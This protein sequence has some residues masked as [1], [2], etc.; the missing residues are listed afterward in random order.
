MIAIFETL[1]TLI[2]ALFMSLVSIPSLKESNK[3]EYYTCYNQYIEENPNYTKDFDD[4][5]DD[6][7]NGKLGLFI[8]QLSSY[9]TKPSQSMIYVNKYTP[10]NFPAL[11]DGNGHY[12]KGWVYDGS[13]WDFNNIVSQNMRLEAAWEK[14]SEHGILFKNEDASQINVLVEEGTSNFDLRIATNNYNDF[15]YEKQTYKNNSGIKISNPVVSIDKEINEYTF[16][17]SIGASKFSKKIVITKPDS[18]TVSFDTKGLIDIS[19][20]EVDCGT[21]LES[22][23]D[24]NVEGY[25]FMGWEY[26]NTPIYTNTILKAKLYSNEEFLDMINKSFNINFK[27]VSNDF[28][29]PIDSDLCGDETIEWK[30]ENLETDG[31]GI[32]IVSGY[33]CRVKTRITSIDASGTE[34]VS[35]PSKC[36][37]ILTITVKNTSKTYEY[38]VTVQSEEKVIKAQSILDLK[39][40]YILYEGVNHYL[41]P[42]EAFKCQVSGEILA[43]GPNGF[44]IFD[45]TSVIYVFTTGRTT[46]DENRKTIEI[47][48]YVSIEGRRTSY[49]N[50]PQIKNVTLI[51]LCEDK[52]V[53]YKQVLENWEIDDIVIESNDYTNYEQFGRVVTVSGKVEVTTNSGSS[54]IYLVDEESGNKIQLESRLTSS[55]DILSEVIERNGEYVTLDAIVYQYRTDSR[56][57]QLT[58]IDE[59]IK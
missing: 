23:P 25:Y 19:P 26:E 21:I 43:I 35:R 17:Y 38:E 8:V 41:V 22:L 44:Y 1:L 18:V 30:C 37:L 54:I 48:D 42:N 47:G 45:G 13:L 58:Y 46:M 24:I 6:V 7:E 55:N 27:T 33:I 15:P 50:M 2:L 34:F 51:T 53:D 57:W 29:L 10:C 36:K 3:L 5:M 11:S 9:Y 56:I 39:R 16:E 31:S 20:I 52:N 59:S 32:E 12:L 49:Y 28:K 4:W 40:N 14:Y